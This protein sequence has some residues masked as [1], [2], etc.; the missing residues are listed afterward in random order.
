[1]GPVFLLSC[2][3]GDAFGHERLC[4]LGR[5]AIA[6]SDD[7]NTMS[8]HRGKDIV[9]RCIAWRT[10]PST[11]ALSSFPAFSATPAPPTM[12]IVGEDDFCL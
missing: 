12:E 5:G 9:S 1:M 8:L 11:T 6:D 4:F 7:A 2:S 3:G 10:P